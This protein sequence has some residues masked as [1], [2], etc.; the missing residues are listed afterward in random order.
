[1]LN[2]L[3]RVALTVDLPE[4]RLES[5][6]VGMIAHIY[7]QGE[8]YEVEF[9]TLNGDLVALVA[10]YPAQIRPLGNHEISHV[11]TVNPTN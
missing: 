11:R 9:V 8:G 3:D 6:D 1:M 10:L 5:G 4:H 2:E 7:N